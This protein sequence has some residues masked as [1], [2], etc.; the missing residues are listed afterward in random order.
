MI[1][2]MTNTPPLRQPCPPGACDCGRE[3][4]LQQANSD[5]RILLLTRTEEK[6]LL[7]RLENLESLADLEKLQQRMYEQLGVR[8]AVA[9]GFNEVRSMRGIKI[10]IDELPG[11]CRKT[12]QALPTAIRRGLEKNP[13]IAYDLLNAHDLFRGI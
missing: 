4:L 12:R 2:P 13:E 11:L 7:E 10:E 3:Q 6:R 9:P 8:V 5:V 1:G